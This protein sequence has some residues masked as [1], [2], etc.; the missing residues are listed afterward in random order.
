[1]MGMFKT[2]VRVSNSKNP[3][4]YF[5]EE[6]WVDSGALYSFIPEDSLEKIGV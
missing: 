1:M 6:F 4:K 3:E 5:E 2:K